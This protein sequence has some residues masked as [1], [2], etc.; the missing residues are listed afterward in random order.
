[1]K[2]RGNLK[3]EPEGKTLCLPRKVDGKGFEEQ[4]RRDLGGQ[5]APE[6]G[7]LDQGH[8]DPRGGGKQQ[9]SKIPA[10]V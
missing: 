2:L 5:R 7:E 6:Q 8:T 4:A 1:M 9:N 3:N 10:F